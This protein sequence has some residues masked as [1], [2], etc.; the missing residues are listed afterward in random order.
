M[1]KS[2]HTAFLTPGV[3]S[4]QGQAVRW[5]ASCLWEA[6]AL[7]PCSVCVRAWAPA[8]EQSAGSGLQGLPPVGSWA[9]VGCGGSDSQ[10]PPA[11]RLTPDL[12]WGEGRTQVLN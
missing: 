4:R 10:S 1:G 5:A 6:W 2:G 11:F 7:T 3:S 9:A 12:C 8:P